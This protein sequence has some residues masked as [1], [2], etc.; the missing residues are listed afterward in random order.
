MKLRGEAIPTKLNLIRQNDIGHQVQTYTNA[1]GGTEITYPGIVE[2]QE[3]SGRFMV[4]RHC[5]YRGQP[6]KRLPAWFPFWAVRM[7]IAEPH[8]GQEGELEGT[9]AAGA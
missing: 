6:Q 9:E 1:H 8:F 7:T 3:P 2:S 5:G 4:P